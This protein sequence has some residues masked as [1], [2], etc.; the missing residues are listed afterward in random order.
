MVDLTNLNASIAA[1]TTEVT[2][3][4]AVDTSVEAFI[5]GFSAQI[6][7]AVSDAL[8][9]DAAANQVSIDAA[10]SAIADVTARFTAAS[11]KL[12]TAIVANTPSA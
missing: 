1:L 4:E 5:A 7:K 3:T 9:A 11:A 6:S 2:N 8:T 12:G 10:N